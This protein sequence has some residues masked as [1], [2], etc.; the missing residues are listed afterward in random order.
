MAFICKM[1]RSCLN[2]DGVR[3]YLFQ[4]PVDENL[5]KSLRQDEVSYEVKN[6][7]SKKYI[8]LLHPHF[9]VI[10]FEKDKKVRVEYV[11]FHPP[12]LR[13]NIEKKLNVWALN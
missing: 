9:K 8:R 13:E 7:A 6:I 2:G 5:Y 11:K 12:Y 3:E 4:K 1:V 10:G